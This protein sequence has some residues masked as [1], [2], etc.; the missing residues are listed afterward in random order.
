MGTNKFLAAL[1]AIVA[2]MF[3]GCRPEQSELTLESLNHKTLVQGTVLY[4]AGVDINSENAYMINRILPASERTIIVEIPYAELGNSHNEG[5]KIYQT[6]TDSAGFFSI[7]LP[8]TAKGIENVAVRMQEFVTA[9]SEYKRMEN[10]APV[11]ET[12]LYRYE[13]DNGGKL[14]ALKPGA[15]LTVDETD[16]H[17]EYTLV[18]ADGLDETITFKGNINVAYETE[19]RT[20]AYKKLANATVIFVAEYAAISEPIE[21]GTTTDANGQYT[22]T[23]PVESYEDGFVSLDVK[24][25]GVGMGYKHFYEVGKSLDLNGAY[26]SRDILS[27]VALDD[28]IE[29]M[30]YRIPDQYIR[31]TPQFNNGITTGV[32]PSTWTGNLAG[33]ECYDGFTETQTIEGQAL[34]P[35]ETAYGIGTYAN[36]KQEVVVNVTYPGTDVR[37]SKPLYVPTDNNGKF[38][39]NIPVADKQEKL[40]V[41]FF[42]VPG[43]EMN[44]YLSSGKNIKIEGDY[45]SRNSEIRELG[46]EWYEMGKMYYR[47]APASP[48]DEM[49]WNANLAGWSAADAEFDKYETP[50]KITANVKLPYETNFGVGSYKNADN[51]LVDVKVGSIT[52]S[53]LAKGG[54]I[55]LD[56]FVE[57][58]TSE[59]AIAVAMA[60][61]KEKAF[62]HFKAEQKECLITG[63]YTVSY[64][65]GVDD[66]SKW[67]ELGDVYFKFEPT[68][69]ADLEDWTEMFQYLAGWQKATALRNGLKYQTQ[70]TGKVMLPVETAFAVGGYTAAD[71]V[72]AKITVGTTP[73]TLLI[74]GGAVNFMAY[75]IKANDEPAIAVARLVKPEE[76]FK[77]YTIKGGVENIPGSYE[78]RN[79]AE[80][81][82][83][84]K[85]NELG[86][87]YCKFI[88]KAGMK[89]E[90]W[91]S[92]FVNLAGWVREP[93]YTEA[94]TVTGTIY[95]AEETGYYQGA[96][97]YAANTLVK[98]TVQGLTY[99][100][101]TDQDG[102]YSIPVLLDPDE[103]TPD[104]A[105]VTPF[106]VENKVEYTHYTDFDKSKVEKILYTAA[107][108]F[109]ADD[110]I[111]GFTPWYNVST[112]YYRSPYYS[113]MKLPDWVNTEK[114]VLNKLEKTLVL[115]GKIKRAVEKTS[116][117]S[118]MAKWEND[119][120]R[121][122][123]TVTFNGIKYEVI[124]G[125]SQF[126]LP[127]AVKENTG[128][129]PYTL[130]IAVMDGSADKVEKFTHY[131][132]QEAAKRT[133]IYGYYVYRT[134]GKFATQKT[135]S[136]INDGM[137]DLTT[138]SEESLKMKFV[139]TYPSA[140]P[141]DWS[142][143]SWSVTDE[144]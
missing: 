38:S 81:A 42:A 120:A 74:K 63:K 20:G 17:C 45:E 84:D 41:S 29:G 48:T 47:F 22:I 90:Y 109:N 66:R 138:G 18:E 9:R 139:P 133:D 97:Q 8:T 59:P 30:E 128:G 4:D 136:M 78:L 83:R 96:Y 141:D 126:S 34:L 24:A 71:N 43:S 111:H 99:V 36:P 14:L 46:A 135:Y 51:I 23:L 73:Y 44:H 95:R 132:N 10:N 3:V 53:T 21:F 58:P 60:N 61:E 104:H 105:S 110:I 57:N 131:L 137:I 31:F 85:W 89:P 67:N 86:D 37:V 35:V 33:W 79:M 102:K 75:M 40:S 68:T 16:Q 113:E 49:E 2:I 88:P 6:V 118:A 114:R 65:A 119:N 27:G 123:V 39:F 143:Y 1:L 134:D 108:K 28:I 55:D 62:K 80:A 98:T 115:K 50:A 25:K 76:N 70:I 52:Y 106:F 129:T 94:E 13:W 142:M 11:F 107:D 144:E 77:H 32:T 93:G 140:T 101:L 15:A 54:K 72:L 122:L 82:D 7:E 117:T 87:I 127:I 12:K 125:A 121:R 103:T 116:G 26:E 130:K 56:V 124:S 5:N 64:M 92:W 112:C 19:Y 91:D 69:P 100:A